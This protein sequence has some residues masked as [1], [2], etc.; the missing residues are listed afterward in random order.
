M[1]NFTTEVELLQSS[2]PEDGEENCVEI[3]LQAVVIDGGDERQG[4]CDVVASGRVFL[5][6]PGASPHPWDRI[7][8]DGAICRIRGVRACRDLDGVIRAYRCT[9]IA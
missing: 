5:L 6:A 8:C 2:G 1:I 9:V 7:R 4:D 3:R